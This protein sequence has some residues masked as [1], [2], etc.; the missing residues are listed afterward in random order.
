VSTLLD[1]FGDVFRSH[2]ASV[3]LEFDAGGRVRTFTFAELDEWSGQVATALARLGVVPGGRV[4]IGF[5]NS[6]ELVAGVLAILRLGA[7]VVPL[8][9]ALPEGDLRYVLGHAEVSAALVSDVPA[10]V[11][12][13]LCAT[14][15]TSLEALVGSAPPS[16]ADRAAG[17]ALRA[18][19]TPESIALLVYTSGTTGRPKGALLSHRALLENL[20]AMAGIWGWTAADR[21]LLTLPCFHL[22][23]L[24]LGC[25]AAFVVGSQILLRPRF[26]APEVAAELAR[27]RATMFFGVPTMYARLVALPP[28]AISG[29]DLSRVR[30]FVSGSAP[31]ATSLASRFRERFGHPVVERFGMTEGGF[32][33]STRPGAERPGSVGWP[34][35]GVECRVMDAETSSDAADGVT[36]ELLVRGSNLFSGYWRD[37][38][39]T[40]RAFTGDWFRTGDLA[41]KDADGS[42]RIVGRISTDII[43]SRGYKIGAVEIEEQLSQHPAV[44]E[45]AVVGVPDADQGERV[46][47]FV[48][49]SPGAALTPEELVAFLRPRVAPHKVPGAV[50]VVDE[51]PRAGPGKVNKRALIEAARGGAYS[52][53]RAPSA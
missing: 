14:V 36:G 40:R 46:V 47:A 38:E 16:P 30:L 42:F 11:A 1:A 48:I 37:P 49:A 17:D 28:E 4:A 7:T 12:G 43:K 25:L 32:M 27:G 22:H 15:V 41:V 44:A 39:A 53:A 19:V 50:V 26:D 2:G 35:P 10:K 8:N 6:P 9:P 3:A 20:R 18:G 23:G 34:V 21:L 24:G 31:L 29:A 13:E 51:L 5:P 52:L 45:A 33:L